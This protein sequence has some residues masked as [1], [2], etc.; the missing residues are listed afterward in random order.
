MKDLSLK[1]RVSAR[2]RDVPDYP[3]PG[4][5][6]KDLTPLMSDPEVF[7]TLIDA[8]ALELAEKRIDKIVGIESRGFIFGAPL[9]L[10]MGLPFVPVR[11][12]G[13]LPWTKISQEYVLEYGTD[14]LEMHTDALEKGDRVV[15]VDD[16]LATGGTAEA[17]AILVNRCAAMV[18]SFFF[19]MELDFLAGRERLK[20][21]N[22]ESIL[23]ITQ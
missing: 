7:A 12:A 21:Q 1:E 17:V 13:K 22:V 6:F 19:V 2:V 23:R 18:V 15:V 8:W 20:G 16:I 5:L 10:K 4:I 11:K 14:C 9:A 3:K